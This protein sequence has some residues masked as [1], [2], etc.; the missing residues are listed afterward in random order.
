M[1]IK[2]ITNCLHLMPLFVRSIIMFRP[3]RIFGFFFFFFLSCPM[4]SWMLLLRFAL[5]FFCPCFSIN[6]HFVLNRMRQP[7]WNEFT[8]KNG[9]KRENGTKK[10]SISFSHSFCLWTFIHHKLTLDTNLF[11]FTVSLQLHRR[12][13]KSKV[14]GTTPKWRYAKIRTWRSHVSYRMR[15]QP[16]KF[17]GFGIT[18]KSSKVSLSINKKKKDASQFLRGAGE[19]VKL[20]NFSHILRKEEFSQ[21]CGENEGLKVLRKGRCGYITAFNRCISNLN[22]FFIL[23]LTDR[24]DDKVIESNRRFTTTSRLQ[25]S[26]TPEEDY[27]EYSCQAKHKAL[28][29]DMPMRATVQLSV[30]CKYTTHTHTFTQFP[31]YHAPFQK[32]RPC[33][34]L[35]QLLLHWHVPLLGR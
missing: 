20:R 2:V 27:V 12:I 5:Y 19:E 33:C 21:D 26:P 7:P 24:R 10:V 34:S 1:G 25:L 22:P 28:Q 31:Q 32:H 9:K 30:L 17:N 29:P 35:Y 4:I 18:W 13:L 6:Y 8:E 16:H 15:S 14:M 3:L 11:T 23:Q